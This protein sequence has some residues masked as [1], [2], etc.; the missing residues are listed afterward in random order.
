MIKNIFNII[1]KYRIIVILFLLV[2]VLVV[3]KIVTNQNS[4]KNSSNLTPTPTI[5]QISLT[6]TQPEYIFDANGNK[7][8]SFEELKKMDSK[9]LDEYYLNNLTEEERKQI[10]EDYFEP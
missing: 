4:I 5:I 2:L 8:I 6:Y 10:P 3:L 9:T 7:K 1:Y